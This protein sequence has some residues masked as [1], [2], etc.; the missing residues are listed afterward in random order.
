M[1][2]SLDMFD[3]RQN[4]TT[5]YRAALEHLKNQ[6]IMSPS[7]LM[8]SWFFLQ[9]RR[10]T[11]KSGLSSKFSLIRPYISEL[12]ALVHLKKIPIDLQWEKCCEHSS[13][14]SSSFL[15]ETRTCIKAWMSLNFNQIRTLT[16]ELPVLEHLK[17]REHS[18]HF[19]FAWIFFILAGNKDNFKVSDEFEIQP[20]PTMDCGAS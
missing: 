10:T 11:I 2:K 14:G 8:E 13:I 19:I 16:M 1:H 20:D 7:F 3:F 12:A 17:N 4:L 9:V 5:V 15:Q 18:S 6:C